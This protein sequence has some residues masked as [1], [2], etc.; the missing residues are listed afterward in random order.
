MAKSTASKKKAASKIATE[1]K[2]TSRLKQLVTE[3]LKED[4]F[5]KPAQRALV[6][7]SFMEHFA[8]TVLD[9]VD[10]QLSLAT[11]DAL[12]EDD[13]EDEDDSAEGDAEDDDSVA[14]GEIVDDSDE[15]DDDDSDEGDDD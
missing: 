15:D 4:D 5:L 1:D 9:V 3:I 7:E 8:Q 10:G 11:H 2:I 13:D 12:G 6:T 14:D